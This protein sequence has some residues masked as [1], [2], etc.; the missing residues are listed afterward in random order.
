MRYSEN[1][2]VIRKRDA[3]HE[4]HMR[5][6]AESGGRLEIPPR[7]LSESGLVSELIPY[8]PAI[9]V[10]AGLSVLSGI[11]IVFYAKRR[12]WIRCGLCLVACLGFGYGACVTGINYQPADQERDW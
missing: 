9:S 10:L 8:G 6:S 7:N 4:E 2:P 5:A 12:D 11:G 1:H 3:S